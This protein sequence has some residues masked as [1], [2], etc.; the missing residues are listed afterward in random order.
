MIIFNRKIV[1]NIQDLDLKILIQMKVNGVNNSSLDD[2]ILTW[3]DISYTIERKQSGNYLKDFL[4][5][6]ENEFI[7][8]LN[9]GELLKMFQSVS[10]KTMYKCIN[11]CAVNGGIHSRKLMAVMGPR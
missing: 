9:D 7:Q 6:S 11:C 2:L 3:R 1:D 8:I 4:G 5:L 10:M